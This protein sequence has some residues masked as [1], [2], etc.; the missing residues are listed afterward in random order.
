MSSNSINTVPVF[1]GA[2]FRTWQQQM[3]DFLR[4]QRLWRI[5]SGAATRPVRNTPA[6]LAAQNAWDEG[7]EQAQGIPKQH[8]LPGFPS[9]W[10]RK[11]GVS[12]MNIYVGSSKCAVSFFMLMALFNAWIKQLIQKTL[13]HGGLMIAMLSV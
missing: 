11:I 1:A 13:K 9:L 6:D 2:N 10:M 7:D 3:G 8:L 4:F 12:G 5:T